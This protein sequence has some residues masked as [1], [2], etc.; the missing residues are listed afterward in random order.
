MRDVLEIPGHEELMNLATAV[1]FD[2]VGEVKIDPSSWFQP[3]I[4]ET[5]GAKRP[6][7]TK[8]LGASGIKSP[9]TTG[10]LCSVNL[11][12][13]SFCY[14]DSNLQGVKPKRW[15]NLSSEIELRF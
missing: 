15:R 4:R 1:S 6:D 2:R 9:S 13:S 7:A 10:V 5:F 11:C 12:M 8:E 14:N 3:C